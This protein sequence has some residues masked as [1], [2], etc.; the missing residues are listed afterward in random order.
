MINVFEVTIHHV[1]WTSVGHIFGTK[2]WT[3]KTPPRRFFLSN[4]GMTQMPRVELESV[5]AKLKSSGDTNMASWK[6]HYNW[7]F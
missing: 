7:K 5:D 6:I 4:Q 2:L 1:K 3:T